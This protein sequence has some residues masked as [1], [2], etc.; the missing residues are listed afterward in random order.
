MKSKS[1]ILLFVSL[2]VLFSCDDGI[3]FD[4]PNDKHN[5][6]AQS[7]DEGQLGGECYPNKTCNKGL[8]C[9]KENN[10]C[11]EESENTNDDEK[12]DTVST[13]DDEPVS[14][15]SDSGYTMPDDGD[16]TDDSGDST[17]DSGDTAPDD[18]TDTEPVQIN[19]CDD[20]PCSGIANST[21]SCAATNGG[22]ACGCLEHYSWTG[23]VCKADS[24]VADCTGR[25]ANAIWNTAESISQTW[26]GEEWYPSEAGTY[27]TNPSSSECRFKCE[28]DYD[29][30]GSQCVQPSTPCNPNP[31]TDITNSNGSC[32]VNGTSYICGCKS[33]YTW[34]GSTC[35]SNGSSTL[36]ECSASTTT[37]PCKDST[38]NYIWSERYGTMAWQAAVDK[39]TSLNSSN[40]GGYSS[41]W[42]LPDIDELRTL[43]IAD[44][45]KN[46]C[47]VSAASG[48]L[49]FRSCWSCSTCTQ[50]GTQSSGTCSSWG[51]SYSD[52]RYSKF[53]ETGVFWSSSTESEGTTGYYA[54][55]VSFN[56]GTVNY[57]GKANNSYYVRCVR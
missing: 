1:L 7:D 18:E 40:Y 39:C 53:G 17:P 4:N 47:K 54:W 44:R 32:T 19:P 26:D 36:P 49:S 2:F 29:W 52:G 11:I 13:N 55:R 37:F 23:S 33:G 21:G 20:N 50:T 31:C 25:P 16:S 5:Q 46:N 30:N 6:T 28:P 45:V 27:N 8:T 51:T 35:A 24:R 3:K 56:V 34:N 10:T 57:S 42:H 48:C 12:T 43:L 15:D 22:Y 9:D 38:T 14:D 41:G